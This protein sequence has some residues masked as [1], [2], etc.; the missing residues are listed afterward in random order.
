[1]RPI[2]GRFVMFALGAF[3]GTIF[4][5]NAV[6]ITLASSSWPGLF[7]HGAYE[8]GIA[9]NRLL[10]AQRDQDQRGWTTRLR[11]DAG[12][13]LWLDLHDAT[14]IPLE[15]L[16]PELELRAFGHLALDH[17]ITL[18]RTGDGYHGAI[19]LAPQRWQTILQVRDAAGSVVYR[20]VGDLQVMP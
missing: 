2:S 20:T 13:G 17:T 18:L 14:G 15:N 11:Y 16:K 10:E 8:R 12:A 1:M 7:E 4:A 9:F 19:V 6:F 3:F 5:V